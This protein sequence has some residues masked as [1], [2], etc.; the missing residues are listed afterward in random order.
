MTDQQLLA[1]VKTDKRISVPAYD[2]RLTELIESAKAAI[3]AEGAR[4][5]DASA[6]A[7]DAEL[8]ILYADWLWDM[9][10]DPQQAMPR[11]LRVKLNNRIFAEKMRAEV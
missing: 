6:D 2:T 9:T 7:E 3:K 8:V 1:A 10:S 4:T 11:G 5:L